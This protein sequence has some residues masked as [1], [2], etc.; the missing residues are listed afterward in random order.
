MPVRFLLLL[1]FCFKSLGNT[2]LRGGRPLAALATAAGLAALGSC[3]A[4]SSPQ[5]GPRDLAAPRLI[6]TSPDSAARNVKQQFIRLTFSEAVQVKDLPK[7]LL[8]TPQLAPDNQYQLREDRSSV[9]LL[10]P[11]P[12]EPNTT[13][14]CP[15]L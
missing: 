10:F 8:I 11:K 12:L 7:N 14:S 13:Y 3:A 5:G 15:E 1:S 4:I 9:T 2:S 6:A